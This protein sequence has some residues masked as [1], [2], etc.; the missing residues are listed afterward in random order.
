VVDVELTVG[1]SGNRVEDHDSAPL[2]PLPLQPHHRQVGPLDPRE[3]LVQGLAQDPEQA[4]NQARDM[5]S[6]LHWVGTM[7]TRTMNLAELSI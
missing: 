4:D 2:A 3:V 7:V 5:R 6:G 1:A